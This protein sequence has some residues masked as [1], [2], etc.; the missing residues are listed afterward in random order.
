MAKKE[1]IVLIDTSA[2]VYRAFHALP[3]LT[4]KKG[5][6]VNAVYGFTSILLKVLKELKPGYVVCA[7]DKKGPT[8]RHK[9]FEAYK[10]H[11]PPTPPELDSQFTIVRQVLETLNIPIFEKA[12]FEADDIIGALN[13]E[14]G[15]LESIIVTGD[16]DELQLIDPKTKVY[17]MRRGFS[18][19][20]IYDQEKV[21]ERYGLEPLQLIDYKA[22][23]GDPSDNIP[24]VPGIGEKT[25]LDL[26]QKYGSLENVYQN[27]EDLKPNLKTTL[28]DYKDQA[29]LSRDLSQIITDIPLDFELEKCR[30]H[31]FNRQKVFDLFQEL[32]FKSLLNK[33]PASLQKEEKEKPSRVS[34]QAISDEKSFLELLKN[35]QKQKVLSLDTETTSK[36]A[37]KADLVGLCLSFKEGQGFYIPLGHD[38]GEQLNINFVLE[39]LKP[40]FESPKVVKIGHNLKYDFLVL[41]KYNVHLS[42]PFFDTMIAAYL[43]NPGVKAQKLEELAFSELGV[44]MQPIHELI[45]KGKNEILFS[46]ISI[47]QAL[48][49]AAEDADIAFRLYNHLLPH[50]KK[51]K[52]FDLFSKIEMPLIPVLAQMEW[53]G[54]KINKNFLKKLSSN[55][56]LKIKNLEKNIWQKGGEKF[57]INSPL[58]LKKIL[59]EKLKLA[60]LEGLKEVLKKVK[61]GGFSTSASMLE[62]LKHYHPIIDDILEYREFVKLKT[63]YIDAL[64]LL[65]D[66]KT[67][68]VHTSFNQAITAT[69]RLSSSNPNLQNIPVRTPTG[70]QIRKAFIAEKGFQIFSFD[71]SQIELRVIAS[72]ACDPKM[73]AAFKNKEDIHKRTAAEVFGIPLEKVGSKE[74]RI[75]KTI[76]FGIIYGIS[77]YG[78][79]Q[80]IGI[81]QIQAQE[82]IEKYFLIHQ[83]IASYIKETIEKARENGY[84]ETFLGRRRYLPE[85]NSPNFQIR[86][87]AERMAI[88]MPIQGTAA[89]LIKKAMIEIDDHLKKSKLKARMVLQI[90][91]ELIFEMPP[92]E[93]EILAPQIKKVMEKTIKLSVPI[94]VDISYGKNWGELKP[95]VIK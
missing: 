12:G 81:S 24:G 58:Q 9:A 16:L 42:L 21:K 66:P 52:L 94:V 30:T 38:H 95:F 26:I 65:V 31:D 82:F 27:L 75:A 2:L 35:I 20:I 71:Y 69:G 37:L 32:G 78:L 5:E 13:Q 64:P 23:K 62:K 29:F 93:M 36:D 45:G 73:I 51:E 55:F 28:E 34:Y 54:I 68:R 15:E 22:L 60:E 87:A 57:N 92:Q 6:L 14:K 4:T 86:A 41:K 67:S 19:T 63:T 59:F 25:A 79:T 33:L 90:H 10:A 77:S 7:F 83:G 70:S 3:P 46:A 48:D 61:T 56:D 11:R 88:N 43:I 40:V 1:K 89:D 44:E 84:V 47:K 49:Y 91:D 80:G 85:I 50:L 72:F 53:D 8:F 74:R 18:D 17:T 76:N 39:R